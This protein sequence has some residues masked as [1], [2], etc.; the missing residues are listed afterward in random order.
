MTILRIYGDEAGTMPLDDDGDVFVAATVSILGDHPKINKPNGHLGWLIDQFKTLNA[1]PFVAFIKPVPGYGNRIKIKL[2][3]MNI[4]A[5]MTRLMTGANAQ[6]LIQEGLPLRNYIWIHCMGLAIA[7]ATFKGGIIRQYID[8]VD[9]LLD[10]K[11]MQVPYR[12]LLKSLIQ[13]TPRSL[14]EILEQAKRI[15]PRQAETFQSRLK[16]SEDTVSLAWSDE[17]DNAN[18]EGGLDLAHY[19]ASHYHKGLK[20]SNN[21]AKLML[22]Q[23]GFRDADK[24]LTDTITSIDP[25]AVKEWEINTGLREPN[26]V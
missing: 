11:T 9:I 23:S 15:D 8:K 25:R 4:M 16:F 10:Q 24:E 21:A 22:S 3:K 12:N 13:K 20:K 14:G 5:R 17:I 1:V 2:D 6:Y 7:L 19:L 18:S 26:V